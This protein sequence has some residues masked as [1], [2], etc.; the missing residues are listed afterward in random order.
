MMKIQGTMMAVA[1]MLAGCA[2]TQDA[3]K[4]VARAV[5]DDILTHGKFERAK[6]LYAPDFKNHGHTRDVGLAEDQA[7][8]RGWRTFAPDLVMHVDRIVAE[9]DMVF[10]LWSARGTNT[11]EGNGLPATGRHVEGRGMT[12]WRIENGRIEEEWSEFDQMELLRQ[13]G[14]TGGGAASR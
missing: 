9:G 11:G 8:A 6:D 13:L 2:T 7:A 10:V 3:N 14:L 1:A 4:D 12:L 5:F